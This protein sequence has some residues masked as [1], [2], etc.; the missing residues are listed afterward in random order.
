MRSEMGLA[1]SC[2]RIRLPEDGKSFGAVVMPGLYAG[3]SATGL[4][5]CQQG[6]LAGEACTKGG[7]LDTEP[8]PGLHGGFS[9][10][11]LDS[12]QQGRL[13][14][15]ACTKGGILDAAGPGLDSCQQGRFTGEALGGGIREGMAAGFTG[16]P[17]LLAGA[18]GAGG[19]AGGGAVLATTL[20]LRCDSSITDRNC[21]MRPVM[22]EA[23]A[24]HFKG[25]LSRYGIQCGPL[26]LFSACRIHR[27]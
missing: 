10:T 20:P 6:R 21:C 23:E 5:S 27:S 25:S 16:G 26:A 15:E 11:G 1:A 19:G 9:A 17:W 18:V 13:A 24:E 2:V 12:C 7:I 22:A 14:G 3:L 4:D 8:G